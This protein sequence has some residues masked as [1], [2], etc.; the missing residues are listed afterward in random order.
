MLHKYSKD[1]L[2]ESGWM[3]NPIERRVW[4]PP[5]KAN[6]RSSAPLEKVFETLPSCFLIAPILSGLKYSKNNGQS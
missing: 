6:P 2:S 3:K 4:V 5:E 1:L